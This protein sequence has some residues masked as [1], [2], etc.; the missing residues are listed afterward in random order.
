MRLILTATI[1][2]LFYISPFAITMANFRFIEYPDFPKAHSSWASIGY[3]EATNKVVVG[4]T[5]HVSDVRLFEWDCAKKKISKGT[6][7]DKANIQWWQW[8]GKIHSQIIENKK[9]GWMYFGTDGGEGR[10]EYYMDHPYGYAG[11]F[12]M[13]Y[14]PKTGEIVNL[15]HGRRYESIKE[16]GIDQVRQKIYG[17]TYPST[18]FIIK[19]L[20]TGIV[21]DKGSLNKAHVGRTA[22]TDDWGNAYYMDMRGVLIKY[23]AASDSFIWDTA[24]IAGDDTIAGAGSLRRSGIRGWSRYKKT[25]QYYFNTSWGRIL[26]F[27]VQERGIGKIDDMGY[28]FDPTDSIPLNKIMHAN[29]PNM[30]CHPNGNIY[31]MTGGHGSFLKPYRSILVEINPV[32]REKKMLMEFDTYELSESTG[33]QTVDKYGNIYFASRKDLPKGETMGESGASKPMLMIFNPTKEIGK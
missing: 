29:T 9:D 18:H 32:T 23:E 28:Y 1:I 22:F 2:S 5:D 4:V 20:A 8:Q 7:I 31:I 30:A 3:S 25:N 33:M 19:D 27:T 14:S 21:V 11:G 15:G 17:I 26:K 13:K 12:F 24:P 16:I 10:E 6:K